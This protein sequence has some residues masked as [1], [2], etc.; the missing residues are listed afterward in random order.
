MAKNADFQAAYKGLRQVLK[1][2]EPKLNV[3]SDDPDRYYLNGAY[4]DKLKRDVFFAAVEIQ[5]NYV[6]FHFMPIYAS[7][8]LQ[9]SLSP[10]LKKRLNGKACFAF[11]RAEPKLFKE[12]AALTKKGFAG[13]K[14]HGYV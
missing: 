5:K 11:T 4:S 7:T 3:V 9:Q 14:K 8:T 10:E 12:L 6:S 13:F 2:Y 1:K